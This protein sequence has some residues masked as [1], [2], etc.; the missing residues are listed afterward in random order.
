MA[1]P[2]RSGGTDS[3]PSTRCPQLRISEVVALYGFTARQWR[4]Q[5]AA[6]RIPGARQPFGERGAWVFDAAELRR[7][8]ALRQRTGDTWASTSA[9]RRIGRAPSVRV[10][11]TAEAS[12][13]R[14]EQLLTDVFARGSPNWKEPLSAKSQDTPTRKL[15]LVSRVSTSRR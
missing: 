7:W 10:E 11:S 3:P 13:Q 6:G 15:K 9:E 12:R 8:W 4:R 2:R 14:T 5:A 1:G